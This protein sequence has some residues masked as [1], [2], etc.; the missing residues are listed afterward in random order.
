MELDLAAWL[1][2]VV[3]KLLPLGLEDLVGGQAAGE[4]VHDLPW[5]DAPSRAEHQGLRDR[6]EDQG[7][8]ALV[9][10]LR[11]LSGSA[12]AHV[13]DRLAHR[14]EEW[15]CPLEVFPIATSHDRERRLFGPDVAA[16]DR[17]V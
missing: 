1:E 16:R 13:N 15:L 6:L 14:L 10:G 3:E 2:V 7:N 12:L 11:Y 17:R 5:I 8:H 9:R 4:H